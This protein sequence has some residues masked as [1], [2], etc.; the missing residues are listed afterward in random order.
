MA[1]ETRLLATYAAGISH[2]DIPE[3]VRARARHLTIDL[4][5]S[6]LR[7]GVEADSTPSLYR[8]VADLG[9]D[10]EGAC[11]VL[12]NRRPFAPPVAALLNG[13]L[14]HSLDFDDTHADSSLHPSAPVVPAAFAV[15]ERVNASGKDVLAA[16]VAGYEVCCRLGN[17]LDPTAHYARGFHPTATAGTFGAAAAAGRLYGLDADAMAS[18]FGVAASQAA[19]SLQFLVNGA[20]NK[21]Y[22]VGA[23]AMNGVIAATLARN[24]FCGA[25]QAIEGRHGFLKGYSDKADPA[26]AVLDLGTAYET[27]RIG[28]KP[29]PSCRYT[30]APLDGL[31]ALKREMGLEAED[32]RSV[33]IGLHQNGIVLTAAPMEEKRRPKSVVDGQFSMP[34][35]A[36]VALAQGSFGWD[37]YARLGDPAIER[38][39]D[40]IEVVRD[41]RLEG[42]RHPFGGIIR[43]ETSQGVIER[44][45]PDPSGEPATF[46]DA[47]QVEAKFLTLAAPVLGDG[48]ATLFA[49]LNT[50]ETEPAIGAILRPTRTG[51]RP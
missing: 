51:T 21:R 33:T 36:A 1:D 6:M 8:T 11:T 16:I 46:P 48:A 9:L 22:Q 47:A 14:G 15:G 3:A 5:G 7:A 10:G 26:R 45:I 34:F 50:V 2:E 25:V 18:A 44:V 4:V 40:R 41:E 39:A 49:R 37:D 31:I 12:G 23:A 24:G 32:I 27:T 35:T 38:I 19:G 28:V 17:A 13:A 43:V 29:Y 20:W 30:H 42:L